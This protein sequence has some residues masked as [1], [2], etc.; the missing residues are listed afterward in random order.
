[1][2]VNRPLV[3]EIKES[4]K[5]ISMDELKQMSDNLYRLLQVLMSRQVAV[6]EEITERMERV[7]KND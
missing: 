4:L 6:E 2:I 1:M 3:K 5:E 7:L